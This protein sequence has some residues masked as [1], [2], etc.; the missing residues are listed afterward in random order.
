MLKQRRLL[1]FISVVCVTSSVL[2]VLLW[3]SGAV[4]TRLYAV[5]TEGVKPIKSITVLSAINSTFVTPVITSCI[6]MIGRRHPLQ[7][8]SMLQSVRVFFGSHMV[9]FF[10]IRLAQTNTSIQPSVNRIYN[11]LM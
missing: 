7:F 6:S 2:R 10:G 8:S 4:N 9:T 1:L 11:Y 5:G 3:R